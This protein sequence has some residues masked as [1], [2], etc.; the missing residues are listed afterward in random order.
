MP[1]AKSGRE[2]VWVVSYTCQVVLKD[3]LPHDLPYCHLWQRV[4]LPSPSNHGPANVV[5]SGEQCPG[6]A[7]LRQEE[8]G[9]F[10]AAPST[11]WPA[12]AL[13]LSIYVHTALMLIR[14][15]KWIRSDVSWISFP[16]VMGRSISRWYPKPPH[17][18]PLNCAS[19]HTAEQCWSL[20]AASLGAKLSQKMHVSC[21]PR[22]LAPDTLPELVGS[23]PTGKCM[24]WISVLSTCSLTSTSMAPQRSLMETQ[25][26]IQLLKKD[27]SLGKQLAI[28][29][30]LTTYAE[31]KMLEL[32]ELR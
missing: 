12:P 4:F 20:T 13:W 24:V 23:R 30:F 2:W 29:L 26:V 3:N 18:P 31:R 19:A 28:W 11:E 22:M 8:G 27:H 6:P 17:R 5:R 21:A 15:Q 32:C 9:D 14:Q 7:V 16:A 25:P 10:F 1:E